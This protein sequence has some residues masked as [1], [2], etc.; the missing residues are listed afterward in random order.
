MFPPRLDEVKQPVSFIF[1]G[2]GSQWPQMG[3]RLKEAFPIFA[4]SL[5]ESE[6]VLDELQRVRGGAHGRWSLAR[7]LAA[8][9]GSTRLARGSAANAV[10]HVIMPVITA[11]Q[12]ALVD[13]LADWGVRPAA[14]AGHSLGEVSAA[15][16][17]GALSR[18][19][20]LRV[21]YFRGMFFFFFFL[22]I[23][24]LLLT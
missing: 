18:E 19:A 21:V 1:P 20:A 22:S 2:Q 24:L 16:C 8:P 11:L 14:V 13:L 10:Y 5:R 15:Y 6:A 12:M 3:Q 17:S 9:E 23:S 4:A 7:E